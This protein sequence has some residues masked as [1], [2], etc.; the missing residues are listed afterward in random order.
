MENTL[1]IIIGVTIVI[2]A[3]AWQNSR[4]F[5]KYLFSAY[6]I[7]HHKEF[8][9]LFTHALLHG[10][11]MHL[12][13]NMLVLWSFG[14]ALIKWFGLAFGE[15]ANLYFV[16]FYI[17]SVVAS[18]LYS[19]VKHKNNPWYSAVGASGAVSAVVFASI[20][21]NPWSMVYFF[22]IV[23]IPGIV[24]GGIYLFYSYRQAKRGTDNIGHD[25]HFWGAVF[26]FFYPVL[27]K[28]ELLKHF[29]VQIQ[30]LPF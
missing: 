7:T 9:R 30:N 11:W 21:F 6:R 5:E 18:S 3:L 12:I 24:F 17:M 10:S 1:Y 15:R 13:I 22:G 26:G 29:I 27:M 4:F 28:P 19:L 2:S 8:I 23:P 16:L 14:M 25:A 20:F